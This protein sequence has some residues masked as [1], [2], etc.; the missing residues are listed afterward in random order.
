ML[1]RNFRATD[2][3]ILADIK[4]MAFFMPVAPELDDD[5]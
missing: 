5:I 4:C 3:N 2:A 1:C